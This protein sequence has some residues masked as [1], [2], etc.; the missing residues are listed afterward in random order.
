MF[1][2]LRK[3]FTLIELL[4]VI[5][6][7]GVLM[8]LLFPAVQS[9]RE[10]ARRT[11]CANNQR[12]VA[13]ALQM[14]HNSMR[15]LPYGWLS[16]ENQFTDLEW[17]EDNPGWSWATRILPYMEQSN[18]Y[19]RIDWGMILY[20]DQMTEVHE[21][22]INLFMCPS[23]PGPELVKVEFQVK[24]LQPFRVNAVHE[25]IVIDYAVNLAR[26]NYSGVFGTREIKTNM[27]NADGLFHRNSDFKF[28]D[29]KD[30]LSYTFLTGERTSEI[31]PSTWVGLIP[32]VE[33]A[34]ALILGT[35]QYPPNSEESIASFGSSHPGGTHFTS[36][37]GAIRFVSDLVDHTVYQNMATRAGGETEHLSD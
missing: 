3:G 10:A 25:E 31:G 22:P 17:T 11:H 2:S 33:D 8:A 6:I 9:V 18:L 19:K 16:G 4:V 23:D 28:R 24:Y 15:Y 27:A 7:I 32:E 12:Q 34:A 1:K 5:A 30:G 29:I 14:H 36:A 35:T 37:D 20:R 21:S 13:L 26:S